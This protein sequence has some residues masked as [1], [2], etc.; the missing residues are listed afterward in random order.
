MWVTSGTWSRNKKPSRKQCQR[1]LYSCAGNKTE[2]T[3]KKWLKWNGNGQMTKGFFRA[4]TY[5]R[6]WSSAME[7]YW[8][9]VWPWSIIEITQSKT[10]WRNEK[11]DISLVVQMNG[12]KRAGDC[13]TMSSLVPLLILTLAAVISEKLEIV[14]NTMDVKELQQQWPDLFFSQLVK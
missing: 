8:M 10:C 4:R 7:K 6:S 13:M 9:F 14:N 3:D 5:I 1:E 12:S 11:F 2:F